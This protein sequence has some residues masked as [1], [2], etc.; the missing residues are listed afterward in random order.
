MFKKIS[1]LVPVYN[2]KKTIDNCIKNI[3]KADKCGLDFEIIVSD[4]NSNDGTIE[5]LKKIQNPKIKILFKDKNEGKGA[6][7]INALKQSEGDLVLFQDADLEY[8]PDNYPDVLSPFLKY[9]ADVVYGSRLTGAKLTKILGFPNLIANKIITL[10]VNILFN[11]IYSDV[12]TGLKVFKK[13]ILENLDL[14]SKGFEIEIEITAKISKNKKINIFEVPI[15]INS[16]RFDEGKKVTI[17]DFFIHI[18]S[19]FKWRFKN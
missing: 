17:F 11:R 6:N 9:N 12:E 14:V 13:N 10:L 5:I 7:I 19:I 15:I 4:N 18:F 8:P 2:E 1:I 3:L 16:R